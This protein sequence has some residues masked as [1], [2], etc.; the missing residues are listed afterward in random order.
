MFDEYCL[1]QTCINISELKGFH[2][3]FMRRD[4][5]NRAMDMCFRD[6]WTESTANELSILWSNWKL[7]DEVGRKKE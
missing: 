5:Q 3:S 7:G 2:E 1:V 6:R 4:I